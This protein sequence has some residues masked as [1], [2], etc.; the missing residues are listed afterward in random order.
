M[1]PIHNHRVSV[2]GEVVKESTAITPHN[3]DITEHKTTQLGRNTLKHIKYKY[4]H[5]QN[6]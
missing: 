4:V 2:E 6:T 5:I 3:N 1:G